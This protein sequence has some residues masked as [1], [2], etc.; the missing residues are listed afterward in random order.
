MYIEGEPRL[1]VQRAAPGG[2]VKLSPKIRSTPINQAIDT[3]PMEAIR[4]FLTET[5]IVDP[6][7]LDKAPYVVAAPERRVMGSASDRLYIRGTNA[8]KGQ[9]FDIVRRGREYR[10]PKTGKLL[11]VET[12]HLGQGEIVRPAT[13]PPC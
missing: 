3:I 1:T 6:G 4:P 2:V 10:D 13:R 5:R 12:R 9:G 8:A 11:G 7:V